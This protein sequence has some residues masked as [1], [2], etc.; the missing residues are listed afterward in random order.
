MAPPRPSRPRPSPLTSALPSAAP[1]ATV[2]ARDARVPLIPG[3]DAAS[4][5]RAH[6]RA[7][8]SSWRLPVDVDVAVLLVSELVTNAVTHGDDGADTRGGTGARGGT[9]GGMAVTML[10]RCSGGELRVE[11]HD[12]SRD[13]PVP[14]SLQ[15]PDDSETGRGLMLVDTLAADWGYYRTPGGKAVYFTLLL[16]D[17]PGALPNGAAQAR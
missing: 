14:V 15:V 5:A 16:H 17:S 6:L 13:M 12:R 8:I 9:G 4:A 7:A 11:V 10:V 1:P 3:P 2:P